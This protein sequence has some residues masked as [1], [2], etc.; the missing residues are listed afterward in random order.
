VEAQGFGSGEAVGARG[1]ASQAFDEEVQD[2]LRPRCGVV[3]TGAARRP[4]VWFFLS[5]SEEIIAEEHIEAAAR[6][7][8]LVGGL[9]SRQGVLPKGFEDMADEGAWVT[10][11]EL[12]VLFRTTDD[13]R[14]RGP[15]GQS[16]RQPSLRSG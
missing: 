8:E 5:T 10:M 2:G 13:T 1:R 15:N 6:K 3:T 9:G 7:A 16:F 4:E 14:R 12:L 11:K